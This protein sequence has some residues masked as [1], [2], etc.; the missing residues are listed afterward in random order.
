MCCTLFVLD[1]FGV[2]IYCQLRLILYVCLVVVHRGVYMCVR[3]VENAQMYSRENV[4]NKVLL[5]R[6]ANMYPGFWKKTAS[7]ILTV[8]CA[9]FILAIEFKLDVEIMFRQNVQKIEPPCTFRA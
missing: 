5:V 9:G 2:N 4:N 8:F 3:A 6:C 1:V 7:R